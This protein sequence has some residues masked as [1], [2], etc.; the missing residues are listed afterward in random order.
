M[1]RM[2]VGNVE[3]AYLEEGTGPTIVFLHGLPTDHRSMSKNLEPAF[4][5]NSPW[6]RVYPDL[7][8]TGETKADPGC[9][10][11]DAYVDAIIAF[12]DAQRRRPDEK[13]A[14]VGQSWG[15]TFALAYARRHPDHLLGLALV[16][17]S[18]RFEA[19]PA[20]KVVIAREPGATKGA[21]PPLIEAFEEVATVQERWVLDAMKE[22]VSPGAREADNDYLDA[23]LT[24]PLAYEEELMRLRLESPTLVVAG[25]QD[26]IVG[27]EEAWE[28]AERQPRGTFVALDR[29]G[30]ALAIEQQALWHTLFFE[31]LSRLRETHGDPA[32]PPS[33]SK[34]P[35]N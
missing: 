26:S 17:P 5:S 19:K 21:P 14:I 31:W 20:P 18:I 28:F 9:K 2:K 30:H 1:Q 15:A 35:S 29:A 16:A 12:V 22:N 32:P 10:T 11:I 24:R 3:F 33:P 4:E 34:A 6:R 7:P 23:V 27:Y 13:I 25:R 8:G